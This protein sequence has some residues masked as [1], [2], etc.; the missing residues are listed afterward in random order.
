MAAL[1]QAAQLQTASRSARLVEADAMLALALRDLCKRLRIMC[2]C[3]LQVLRYKQYTK[4]WS[5]CDDKEWEQEEETV[6]LS[7]F[8][9][10]PASLVAYQLLD[11]PDVTCLRS[12]DTVHK[13]VE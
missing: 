9:C 5:E 1:R 2:A 7:T 3:A 8:W 4:M 6:D 10:A 13:I 11:A 12:I